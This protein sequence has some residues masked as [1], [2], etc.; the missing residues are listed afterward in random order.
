MFDGTQTVKTQL[1][2]TVTESNEDGLRLRVGVVHLVIVAMGG[3][4][5]GGTR[6][7]EPVFTWG[8]IAGKDIFG[9]VGEG[10]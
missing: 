7:H 10:L 2:F 8:Q 5:L 1:R 9:I 4:M 6:V 3:E